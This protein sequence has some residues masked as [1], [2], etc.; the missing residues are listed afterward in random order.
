L[1]ASLRGPA[2]RLGPNKAGYGGYSELSPT[3]GAISGF[4]K[5]AMPEYE[6][7]VILGCEAR[8]TLSSRVRSQEAAK[9]ARICAT[10]IGRG[11]VSTIAALELEL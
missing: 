7:E 3:R 5:A 9:S 4:L 8:S 1:T 10:L 2:L 11:D 6:A